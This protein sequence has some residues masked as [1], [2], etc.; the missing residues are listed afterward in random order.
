MFNLNEFFALVNRFKLCQINNISFPV[1]TKTP[2]I[3]FH[4]YNKTGNITCQSKNTVSQYLETK[5][6]LF[7]KI[8]AHNFKFFSGKSRHI[9]WNKY[10]FFYHSFCKY[11]N[12]GNSLNFKVLSL[13][14]HNNDIIKTTNIR[15]RWIYKIKKERLVSKRY[16]FFLRKSDH[17]TWF[18]NL[19]KNTN[20][21][22]FKNW[23]NLNTLNFCASAGLA[24][25]FTSYKKLIN[26]G[27]LYVN[28][29]RLIK[30]T[31]M[32]SKGSIVSFGS[33]N[34][35]IKNLLSINT[36]INKNKSKYTEDPQDETEVNFNYCSNDW[37][38]KFKGNV[39][40]FD[41]SSTSLFKNM[42]FSHLTLSACNFSEHADINPGF[43]NYFNWTNFRLYN[44]LITT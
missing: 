44:W 27:C 31:S 5:Q 7:V 38:N 18:I 17:F 39:F 14:G 6:A 43:N 15:R 19:S 10:L 21:V 30:F 34:S 40:F 13:P 32:I 23:R 3:D 20:F 22:F 1:A 36:I 12:I 41:Y 37:S 9:Y 42:D 29:E 24:Y 25:N 4:K 35:D 8:K 26:S 2:R 28:G 11:S 33:I 16:F